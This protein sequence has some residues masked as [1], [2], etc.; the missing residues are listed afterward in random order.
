MGRGRKITL[1]QAVEQGDTRLL[2]YCSAV[3][4]TAA[5]CHRSA[6]MALAPVLTRFGPDVRL[7]ELPFRCT[8]CGERRTDVR[9]DDGPKPYLGSRAPD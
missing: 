8:A 7:D 6:A 3:P 1:G 5:G 4:A 2:I 9:T